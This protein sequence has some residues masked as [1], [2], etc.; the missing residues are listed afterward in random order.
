MTNLQLVKRFWQLLAPYR[1]IFAA[2]MVCVIMVGLTD[3][4]L[5]WLLGALLDSALPL[6]RAPLPAHWLPA[7]FLGLV[8][9]RS[10]FGF[11]HGYIGS[12]LEATVQKDLRQRGGGNLLHWPPARLMSSDQG[13]VTSHIIFLTGGLVRQF[14]VTVL[15]TTQEGVKIIFYVGSLFTIDWHPALVVFFVFAPLIALIR[16]INRRIKKKAE[17]ILDKTLSSVGEIGQAVSM[18]KI[19]KAYGGQAREKNR[20]DGIFHRI[21]GQVIR[22]GIARS[23]LLPL[24]QLVFALPFTY[25][26]YYFVNALEN[27]ALTPGEVSIFIS[28]LLLLN[29]SIR[30]MANAFSYWVEMVVTARSVFNFI[31]LPPETDSGATPLAQVKGELGFHEVSYSYGGERPALDNLSLTVPAGETIA[32]VGRS[33]AGKTTLINLLPRFLSP[34][35]GVITVDGQDIATLKLKDLRRHIDIVTQEALLFDDTVAN[36]IIYP[37]T[38]GGDQARLARAL[39]NAA[40]DDFVYDLPQGVGTRIGENGRLLSGGQRQ[41]LVLARAFYRNAPILILDEATSALDSDT[42]SKIQAALQR[43]LAG[44][45]AIIIAHRF[46]SINY[47]DRIAVLEHGKLLAVGGV[48][49]LRQTCPLFA[50]MYNAQR[51]E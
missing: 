10:L 34:Q 25:I 16:T 22:L 4:A 36:N 8:L 26:I 6:E 38:A 44:R 7:A 12:W 37:D 2:G 50:D 17:T 42:E 28:T 33:G 31:D 43:L 49:E 45:T 23:A 1:L 18:W 40:A 24:N 29:V 20:Q 47:A 39:K 9:L 15:K 13:E 30:N 21:R 14:I 46:T 19:I 3:A 51:L 11:G 48:S 41:R 27:N 32:L 35:N 5:P